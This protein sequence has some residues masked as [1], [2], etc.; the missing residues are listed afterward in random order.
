MPV[1]G[2]PSSPYSTLTPNAIHR[3]RTLCRFTENPMQALRRKLFCLLWLSLT[4]E[5]SL[6]PKVHAIAD[7]LAIFLQSQPSDMRPLTR[8]ETTM[9][10]LNP[11][12]SSLL[13]LPLLTFL[14]I[15]SLA[16]AVPPTTQAS[17]LTLDEAAAECQNALA[18]DQ[19]PPA[20]LPICQQ[21]ADQA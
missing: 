8:T 19:C 21:A 16:N 10:K 7:H 18:S 4:A 13:V 3:S 14:I 15:T 1:F 9:T 6:R 5:K 11:L 17:Q 2:T 12:R 20:V